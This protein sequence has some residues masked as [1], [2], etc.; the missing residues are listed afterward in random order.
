MHNVFLRLNNTCSTPGEETL[1]RLLTEPSFDMD[2]SPSR[3][4]LID[5][6]RASQS[7]RIA[8][9]AILAKLGKKRLINVTD[10]LFHPI[11]P[12]PWKSQLYIILAAI[13]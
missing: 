6:L 10:Y 4:R 1:Y 2:E 12:Q 5:F 8:I 7:K 9:Q 3:Q 11:R 13:F